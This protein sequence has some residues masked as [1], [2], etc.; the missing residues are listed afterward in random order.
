MFELVKVLVGGILIGV[1]IGVALSTVLLWAFPTP[2][3][4]H[5]IYYTFSG[6]VWSFIVVGG[7]YFFYNPFLFSSKLLFT[8][9]FLGSGAVAAF[10]LDKLMERARVSAGRGRKA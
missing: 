8:C 5:P 3:K 4:K 10:V 9:L 7:I 1:G 6:F 2:K